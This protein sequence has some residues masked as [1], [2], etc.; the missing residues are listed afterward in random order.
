MDLRICTSC[1]LPFKDC[2]HGLS[3]PQTDKTNLPL[4]EELNNA[5]HDMYNQLH[6]KN[7]DTDWDAELKKL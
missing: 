5:M 4:W 7:P 6:A 2:L 1:G 3:F